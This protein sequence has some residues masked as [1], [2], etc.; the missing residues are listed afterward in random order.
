MAIGFTIRKK[1]FF[2]SQNVK[3][4]NTNTRHVCTNLNAFPMLIPTMVMEFNN[5]DICW[6]FC[7]LLDLSSA[8]TCRVEKL[9]SIT[10]INQSCDSITRYNTYWLFNFFEL[11]C[12]Q[13]LINKCK[14]RTDT[15]IS[16]ANSNFEIFDLI[17]MSD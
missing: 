17:K 11:I 2:V 15:W 16:M 14:S 7:E 1:S 3:P 12:P 8:H 5:L 10:N 9:R 4:F 13:V 6:H